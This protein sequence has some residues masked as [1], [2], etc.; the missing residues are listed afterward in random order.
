MSTPIQYT[1]RVNKPIML[2]SDGKF[3]I[4]EYVPARAGETK[5]LFC[6]QYRTPSSSTDSTE[7]AEGTGECDYE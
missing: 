4:R 5:F 7:G 1:L 6:I 3:P 2:S